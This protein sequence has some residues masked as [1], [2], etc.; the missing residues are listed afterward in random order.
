MGLQTIFQLRSLIRSLNYVVS[1]HAAEALEDDELNILDLENIILTGYIAHVSATAKRAK[2]SSSLKA[3]PKTASP[4][5]PLSKS[6]SQA[7]SSS[8]P[9]ISLKPH[10]AYCG[11]PEVQIKH[12]TRSFGKAARLLVIEAMPMFDC[13]SCGESYFSA[14]TLHEVERIKALRKS[15]AVSRAVPVAAFEALS[16]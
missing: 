8:L 15:L 7:S 13:P 6:A 3:S 1:T 5:K 4:R 10:C 9:S 16:G 11:S 2:S 12:V 14:Q